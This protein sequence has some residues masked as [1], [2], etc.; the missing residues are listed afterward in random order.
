MSLTACSV[1]R[2]SAQRLRQAIAVGIGGLFYVA[3]VSQMDLHFDAYQGAGT[4]SVSRTAF[5]FR[6]RC[7]NRDWHTILLF[8]AGELFPDT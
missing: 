6:W 1:K 4:R 7:R 8:V 2:Q 3:A 5:S